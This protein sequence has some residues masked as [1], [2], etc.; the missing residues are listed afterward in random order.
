MQQRVSIRITL[1]TIILLQ[2]DTKALKFKFPAAKNDSAKKRQ[3]KSQK[4]N[5][6][7]TLHF[8]LYYR[9]INCT[10]T[11]RQQSIKNNVPS[12]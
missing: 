7:A 4:L 11:K 8:T 3:E 12:Y 1:T 5:K 9:S 2:N 6:L 10:F